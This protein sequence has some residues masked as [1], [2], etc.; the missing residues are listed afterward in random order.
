M[1]ASSAQRENA[2]RSEDVQKRAIVQRVTSDPLL[3]GSE[4]LCNLLRYLADHGLDDPAHALKEYQIATDVFGRPATFDPRVDSTVRVQTGRLRAKLAE[5]Y[6]GAGAT[7]PWRIEIPKGTYSV[8]FHEHRKREAQ[9]EQ[10]LPRKS[11]RPAVPRTV[12]LAVL[13][14]AIAVGAFLLFRQSRPAAA[15]RVDEA[16]LDRFWAAALP[17]PDPPLVV[18]SNAEFVGRPETGLRY[19]QPQHDPATGI[20]DQYTGVGEVVAVHD[21]DYLFQKLGR[22][23]VLKRARLLNW[24][25]TENRDLIFVGSPSENLPVR[26]VSLNRHFVFRSFPGPP[27]PGDLAIVN[28]QPQPGQQSVYFGSK[29]LPITE[30]YALVELMAGT[31]SGQRM[32][33]AAGTT[34][35]GTQAAVD[36]ICHND[37]LAN[38]LARLGQNR[39]VAPLSVLLHVNIQGGVPLASDV[40]AIRTD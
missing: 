15:N 4:A 27:R 22:R 14:V 34:T 8:V 33:L 26:A 39:K 25:D 28:L 20:F 6:T 30:D 32:L 13:G 36:F 9:D 37:K 2:I 24:D 16:A 31:D 23:F 17:H 40:V 35:F 7:D 3:H 1:L 38:L 12:T 21:L 5:Y 18:F 11:W 29:D 19:L 10:Q